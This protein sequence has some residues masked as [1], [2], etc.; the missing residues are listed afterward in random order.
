MRYLVLL[1][2]VYALV[3]ALVLP[4]SLLAAGDAPMP[5]AEPAP[6]GEVTAA[7]PEAAP[8]EEPAPV[9]AEPPTPAEAPAQPAVPAEQPA[10][11]A[12]PAQAPGS[13]PSTVPPPQALPAE[14]PAKDPVAKAAASASVTIRD[15]EFA[16][17]TVTVNVGDTVTWTNNGPTAHSATA[18]D[19]SFDTGVYP[20]GESRS[21]TFESAGTFSYFCKPHPNMKGTVIVQAASGEG[22]ESAPGSTESGSTDSGVAG[23]AQ[24]GTDPGAS[25]PATGT[26]VAALALLGFLM[27]ALGAAARRRAAAD[28]PRPAGRIGW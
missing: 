18:D 6:G 4:S 5:A 12:V 28:E 14:R 16:P 3:A 10:Q 23:D 9:P 19:G 24:S 7:P 17:A 21:H 2:A 25:L 26:D 22:G 1:A 13:E 8:V 27:L 11:P 15:F 20:K